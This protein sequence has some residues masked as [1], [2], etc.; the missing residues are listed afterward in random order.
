MKVSAILIGEVSSRPFNS[1]YLLENQSENGAVYGI[2]VSNNNDE[3]CIP[4]IFDDR[5]RAERFAVKMMENNVCPMHLI[6]VT[7]DYF[8]EEE[9]PLK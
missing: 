7:D 2:M 8:G 9:W 1:Y 3:C 6:N 4:G 5:K